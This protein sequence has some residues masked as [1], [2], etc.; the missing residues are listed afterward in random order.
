MSSLARVPI[1][2]ATTSSP[3]TSANANWDKPTVN[4]GS[5]LG[6]PT[7]DPPQS[8]ANEEVGSDGTATEAMP[9]MLLIAD[10]AV[11]L[12]NGVVGGARRSEICGT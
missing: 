8:V 5:L 4:S 1:A 9:G 12:A 2:C 10:S 11:E 7:R 3:E 6:D